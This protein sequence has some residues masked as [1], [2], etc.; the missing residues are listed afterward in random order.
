MLKA[1][2][3]ATAAFG[4][5]LAQAPALPTFSYPT[6]FRGDFKQKQVFPG[7]DPLTIEITG[8]GVIW[9]TEFD[10]NDLAPLP[11]GGPLRSTKTQQEYYL[12]AGTIEVKYSA[13]YAGP[14]GDCTTTGSRTFSMPALPRDA[15]RDSK[16]F[17][18]SDHTYSL[19][20]WMHSRALVVD[21][22]TTC[23]RVGKTITTTKGEYNTVM[24]GFKGR[25]PLDVRATDVLWVAAGSSEI[26]APPPTTMEGSWNF[27]AH[28]SR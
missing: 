12:D 6:E 16:L 23:R 24:L 13:H 19:V 10:E 17:I 25:K 27:T 11:G 14:E 5:A 18:Y 28:G 8:T 3:L 2:M 26:P 15:L 7:D 21:V 22:K 1:M 9:K 20:L 4:A